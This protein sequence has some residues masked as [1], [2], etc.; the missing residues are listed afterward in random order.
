[1][2]DITHDREADAAYIV[3]SKAAI[4][5]QVEHGPFICDMDEDGRLVGIEILGASKVIAP[6]LWSTAGMPSSPKLDAAE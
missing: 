6:G 2:T 3:I 5:H 1:M 4:D